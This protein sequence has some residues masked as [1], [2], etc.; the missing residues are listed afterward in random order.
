VQRRRT[1]AAFSLV[2]VMVATLLLSTIA[3]AL[4]QTLVS[5]LRTRARNELWMQATQLAA[6]GIE[7]LRA[8]H[9]LRPLPAGTGFER[10]GTTAPWDGHPSVRRLEVTVS[11]NDGEPQRFQLTTLARQ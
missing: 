2:E 6:E 4:T 8:G 11:W 9:T 10:S 7:Q 1:S 5:A 3:L